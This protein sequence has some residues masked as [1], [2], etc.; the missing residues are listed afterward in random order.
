[1]SDSVPPTID[2]R[3]LLRYLGDV[4]FFYGKNIAAE[5][6]SVVDVEFDESTRQIEGTVRANGEEFSPMIQVQMA[7]DDWQIELCECTC[8][9]PGIC[10]H[11]A[12]LAI[13]SNKIASQPRLVAVPEEKS[14][15]AWA[16]QIDSWF[17]PSEPGPADGLLG[18]QH[19][20]VVAMGL[21]F[22][23]FDAKNTTQQQQWMPTG[24][25]PHPTRNKRFRLGVRPMVRNT[26]GRWVR[27][28]LR[29]TTLGFKTYG[30]NLLRS[31]HH[32]FTRFASMAR[33]DTQLQFKV[34]EDWLFMDEYASDLLWPLLQQAQELGIELISTRSEQRIRIVDPASFSMQ[35]TLDDQ[36]MQLSGILHVDGQ[37]LVLD[38]ESPSGVIADHGFY[39]QLGQPDEIW[40][41]PSKEPVAE[42]HRR[43][44]VDRRPVAIPVAEIDS[45]FDSVYPRLAR[46]FDLR[47]AS[48][49]LV[50]PDL[51]PPYVQATVTYKRDVNDKGEPN[52]SATLEFQIRYPGVPDQH[53]VYD[54]EIEE[55]LRAAIDEVFLQTTETGNPDLSPKFYS[56]ESVITFVS[57]IL[58]AI[59]SLPIVKLSEKGTRPV[60]RQLRELPQLKINAVNHERTDWLDLGLLITVGDHE[61]PFSQIV[62]AMSNGQMKIKLPDNTW[63]S[64]NQPLFAKLKALVDEAQALNDKPKEGDLKLTVFQISIFEELDELAEGI[65]GAD[66]FIARMRSLLKVAEGEQAS[67][68]ETLNAQLRPYQVDGFRWLSRLYQGGFGGILADDMGLGKTL[69]TIALIL[70]AHGLWNDSEACAK[71]P[72]AQRTAA[73][74]LVVAPSSVVSNWETEVK[75]FAPS[76]RVTSI[77]GTLSSPRQLSELAE[78]YDVIL[79]TY[80][81]LRL[82]DEIYEAQRFAGLILDEAQFVKNRSTKAHRTA[83]NLQTNFKLAVT[84]TP[85]EN[86]L[87]ELGAL[88]SLVAPAL[89]LNTSRFNRQ[90]ARPIEVLGDKETLALLQRRIKP[91]MLRRTKESVVLDLPAKQEQQLLVRL[92][93]EHQHVYDTH[94]N[95]ERQKILHLVEDLDR[96]RFT[97]FQSLTHLRMLA[98]EPSLVDPELSDVPGS[99][100]EALFDQ[101]DDVLG[102][103]HRALVFSQF[104]SYL[105]VLAEKLTER[106]VNFVYLDGNTRNRSKVIEQF[107]EGEAPLFLISLKAGG[108][109]L[110]LTEADYCFLL[111]P[112]WNPAVEAQAI[113]RTH[114]IGQT[115]QVMVYRMISQGTI[116]EKVV[117]LQESK[118]KLISTVMDEAD[119]FSKALTAQDIRGLLE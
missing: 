110:N 5:E 78:N 104:T 116:E 33:S 42:A 91:F 4:P 82:N 71:L 52:D 68:P 19:D 99:K 111:D 92:S 35:A 112:W 16:Q 20:P 93:D 13:V 50:L 8:D 79:T 63:F 90:F 100:L 114:R 58:P 29:W 2:A 55:Q 21:Q 40:L 86:N 57:E 97:I 15:A 66:L 32:W 118:R 22:M 56:G 26:E 44:Y 60:F 51:K 88:L 3:H 59:E 41:A 1:M 73:P 62:E 109:G 31:Q 47:S 105:K 89:F 72:A 53:E 61:V 75:R 49:E 103:G 10:A 80:T 115:R 18:S 119:G 46:R 81:L 17:Q 24:T 76:L 83:V 9:K 102:E 107:K 23:L 7:G 67:V 38:S 54:R 69:Q 30:W 87:S 70:H 6:N 45:F 12:A 25:I 74:F 117:A 98:L 94:L 84:G 96:N 64:L 28:Q 106:G 37:D 65:D 43:W 85:M 14:S 39:A 95:R 101:L 27:G 113:D 48:E 108:F 77:E 11:I 34:D 36:L